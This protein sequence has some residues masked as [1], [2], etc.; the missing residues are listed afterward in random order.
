MRPSPCAVALAAVYSAAC[1]PA[2]KDSSVPTSRAISASG[3][4][5]P[6]EQL[7]PSF[8]PSAAVQDLITLRGQPQQWQAEGGALRHE[9]GRLETDGWL[10]QVGVDVPNLH[11]I[12]GPYDTT[13]PAGPN[14][15]DFR[16][17]TDDNTGADDAIVT[18]DVFDS[19]LGQTLASQVVTRRMFSIAGDY[20]T[21]SLPF[22]LAADTH[23][24]ELRVLW[25]GAA[26][27]KVDWVQVM[28]GPL[29]DELVTFASL[30]GVVNAKQPRIFSYEGDAFAEG[31][32]AWLQA[33]GLGWNEISDNWQLVTKYLS[34]LDGIIVYDNAQPDTINLATTLAGAKHALVVAPSLVAKLT[35]APYNLPVLEDFRGKFASKL[36]VYQTLYDTYWPTLSHRVAFGLDPLAVRAAVR[37][38]ATALGAAALWLDPQVPSEA[39]LLDRF[40]SSMGAGASW[41]GWWPSEGPGV[42]EASKYG[43]ATIASDY[44]TNL[45]VHSG[46]PRTIH[47]KPIPAKPTL[48]NKLYVAFILSDGDNLQYV[49][50]L[51]RKLWDNPDR[52]KVPMGWTLSPAM[53]DA[54][55]GA[56][57]ALWTTSTVNDCLLSGP[58]GYGYTYPNLWADA[59][60]LDQFVRKTD[61]YEQRA[62]FRVITVWNTITGGI[63]MNVGDSY[64]TNAPS[65]LGVTAQN[66]GGGLTIYGN[67]LPGLALACNY[68]TGEQAMKD[69]IASASQGWTRATPRFLVIQAQPWMNVTPTSFMNV[70]SSLTSD[71]VVVRPDH[72]FELLRES[73]GLPINPVSHYTIGASAGAHGTVSP[74]GSVALNQN[75]NQAFTFTPDLGYAV[76]DVSV[77]GE[78]V[79][80]GP[81]YAFT[82]VT[83]NHTLAVSF[84]APGNSS[85]DASADVPDASSGDA[86]VSDASGDDAPPSVSD[87]AVDSARPSVASQPAG[88][89]CSVPER[90][91][92]GSLLKILALIALVGS[93]RRRR[94][95]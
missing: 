6:A 34:E 67:S 32:H 59:A 5:W 50:H 20:V 86:R 46:T 15:A 70:A 61:S 84:A 66:T 42:T 9:T 45:T 26:Y 31:P 85:K 79:G 91:N 58:S 73:N 92:E 39:Q 18:L 55:P 36:A 35:A 83:A 78:S 75:E 21:F 53:V 87:A 72:L 52:G 44:A 8:P 62:G 47:V 71:Y 90:G 12:Y 2:P 89:D 69:F 88:C 54:M 16:L 63:D 33:L 37:E 57:D 80:D 77:D 22:T 11:M 56:L 95:T 41:M 74:S 10:C 40:L 81:S 3:P 4:T 25:T 29:E 14:E 48:A 68:C 17:K 94:R 43:V 60:T 64:A 82:N 19:T 27:T 65:L 28:R 38:Y 93:A 1:G 13:I 23:A 76:G 49:E 7:L 24:L 51:E 30:K